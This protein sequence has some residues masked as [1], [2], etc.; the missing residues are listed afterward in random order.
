MTGEQVSPYLQG[1][2]ES[3]RCPS[4]GHYTLGLVGEPSTCSIHGPL[5]SSLAFEQPDTLQRSATDSLE[6]LPLV[7]FDEVPLSDAIVTL[8]RQGNLN[9]VFDPEI[10]PLLSRSL[11]IRLENL[12]A[13]EALRAILNSRGLRLVNTLEPAWE[14]AAD[15]GEWEGA[16]MGVTAK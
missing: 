5:P 6:V 4:G 13:E 3:V 7:L 2:L 8:G 12:T 9:L 1:G 15:V 11:T 10:E 14:R 16:I